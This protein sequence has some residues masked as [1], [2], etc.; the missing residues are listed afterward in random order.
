MVNL[1]KGRTSLIYILKSSPEPSP[2]IRFSPCCKSFFLL[3][4]T[5][6]S[7]GRFVACRKIAFTAS[8]LPLLSGA[9][10]ERQ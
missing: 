9:G 4:Q 8:G 3:A 2:A 10:A 5:R 6:A 1:H 7:F